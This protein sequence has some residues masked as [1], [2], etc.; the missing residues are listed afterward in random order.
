MAM[1]ACVLVMFTGNTVQ[2]SQINKDLFVD[3]ITVDKSEAWEGENLNVKIGFSEKDG[4]TFKAGDEM[5]FDLPKELEGFKTS[6]K[7]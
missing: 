3:S 2:A 1:L 6:M 4:H 5:V 7:L